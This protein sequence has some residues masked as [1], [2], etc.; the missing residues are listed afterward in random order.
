MFALIFI[1]LLIYYLFTL[2]AD[3]SPRLSSLSSL[4]ESLPPD[5]FQFTSE[6]GEVSSC[7]PTLLSVSR[8]HHLNVCMDVN[9]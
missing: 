3:W 4:T 5:V 6:K 8:T 7:E 1:Y 2:H 9:T